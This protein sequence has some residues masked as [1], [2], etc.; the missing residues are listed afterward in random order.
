MCNMSFYTHKNKHSE[1]YL[2]SKLKENNLRSETEFEIR[3]LI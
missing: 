3:T 1:K 2:F